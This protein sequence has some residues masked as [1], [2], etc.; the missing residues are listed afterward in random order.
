MTES[1]FGGEPQ[2]LSASEAA[3]LIAARELSSEELVAACLEQ[4][5]RLEPSVEAWEFLDPELALGEARARDKEAPR[6]PLH[7]V[8]VGLKDVIDTADMPT[9]CGTPIYAGRQSRNDAASVRSLRAAGAVALGKTVTTE[10]ATWHPNKTHNPHGAEHTPGGSSSGSAAAVGARMVPLALGT[11]TVGSTIRPASFCGVVG[12]KP[13]LDA[14]DLSGVRRTSRLLD[15]LGLFVRTPADLRLLLEALGGLRA[16]AETPSPPLRVG[17]A[18]TPWWSQADEH[19]QGAVERAAEAL[20]GAGAMVAERPLP[21]GFD[22]LDEAHDV[23]ATVDIAAHCGREFDEYPDLLSERMR[24]EIAR[25]RDI[26]AE[27]YSDA[28]AAAAQCGREFAEHCGDLDVVLA[29]AVTGEAPAQLDWTGDPIFCRPWS[30]LGVPA[31]TVP[32]DSGERGLPIG[33]QL[34]APKRGERAVLD[35]VERL[36]EGLGITDVP[37]P[38]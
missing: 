27:R 8:P 31:A 15:T 16:S 14:V 37:P 22:G 4:I 13:T 35:A 23:V 17:L 11:Q 25:G 33:V 38:R 34:I 21:A 2:N 18:Q 26:S 32:V 12:M 20:R 36:F 29:P 24:D 19:S 1:S 3:R 5:E 30:M 10:L 6:G 9:Q 7:G 28:V